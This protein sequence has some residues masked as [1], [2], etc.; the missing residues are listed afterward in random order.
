MSYRIE[1]EIKG[2]IYVY[3]A[4]SYW[5]KDKKKTCQKREIIGKRDNTTGVNISHPSYHRYTVGYH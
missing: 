3:E 2:T 5:D 4:T 1:Q